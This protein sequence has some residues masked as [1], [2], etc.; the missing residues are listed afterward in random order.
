[1]NVVWNTSAKRLRRG[2][3]EIME[4]GDK[5]LMPKSMK[6]L[7]HIQRCNVRTSPFFK[8]VFDILH[9]SCYLE[10]RFFSTSETELLPWEDV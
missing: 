9:D 4:L 5:S 8:V 3:M 2:E 10:D 7:R 1:M 6:F